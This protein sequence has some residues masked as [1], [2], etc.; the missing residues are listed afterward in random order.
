[1]SPSDRRDEAFARFLQR[2]WKHDVRPL[3]RGPH[4]AQRESLAVGGAKFGAVGGGVIDRLLGLRGR[5]FAR[6]FTVMGSSLGA[7]LPD[8]WDWRWLRSGATEAQR[9]TVAETVQQSA[10][11]LDEDEAL[12]LF[13]LS[14][15]ASREDLRQAW[16]SASQRWHPDKART[17]SQ[18]VEHHLRFI[19]YQAAHERLARAYEQGRLPRDAGP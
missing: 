6:F 11:R 2:V 18:R 5:P 17:E 16:R 14:P 1:M 4:A 12:A 8:V 10:G 19:T 3:L 15:R 13:G 7:L 9:K